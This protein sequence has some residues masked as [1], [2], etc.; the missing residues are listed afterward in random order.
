M[1]FKIVGQPFINHGNVTDVVQG[2]QIRE[3]TLIPPFHLG[4]VSK[5]SEED[6]GDI[7]VDIQ[8]TYWPGQSHILPCCDTNASSGGYV[9]GLTCS[10]DSATPFL[11]WQTSKTYLIKF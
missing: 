7:F 11:Q 1:T 2:N 4:P 8:Y 5:Y 10:A 9:R 3:T 6:C